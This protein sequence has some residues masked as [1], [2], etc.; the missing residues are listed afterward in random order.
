M[1]EKVQ[2][3]KKEES[4]FWKGCV[5]SELKG[6]FLWL[7]ETQAFKNFGGDSSLLQFTL[8]S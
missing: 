4:H 7:G 6:A 5:P 1:V 3:K 2:R 8:T